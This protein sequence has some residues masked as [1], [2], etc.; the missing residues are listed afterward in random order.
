MRERPC[1][2]KTRE[3]WTREWLLGLALKLRLRRLHQRWR[4]I[5]EF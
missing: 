4:I 3:E 2:S 5:D 1:P